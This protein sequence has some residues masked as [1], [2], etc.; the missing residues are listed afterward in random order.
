MK[1][2]V[3]VIGLAVLVVAGASYVFAGGPGFGRGFGPGNCP[4]PGAGLNLTQEQQT[5]LQQ[6]RQKHFDEVSPLRETMF[7]LRKELN[8]L[9]ADPSADPKVIQDKENQLNSLRD[10]MRDKAVQFKLEVR[11]LLTPEQIASFGSGC[12]RGGRGRGPF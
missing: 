7:S 3:I 9:W 4:G 11:S 8:T 12:G 6:M 1:K 5:S 10:Q 2:M